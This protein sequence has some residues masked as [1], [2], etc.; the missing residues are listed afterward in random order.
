MVLL[1][2]IWHL[3]QNRPVEHENTAT[4]VEH[5]DDCSRTAIRG[6]L[7]RRVCIGSILMLFS[8]G[9]AATEG[10]LLAK[11]VPPLHDVQYCCHSMLNL[12]A[13]ILIHRLYTL[14]RAPE[15]NPVYDQA[16]RGIGQSRRN[17]ST[18]SMVRHHRSAL[19]RSD[20][21][22]G[23]MEQSISSVSSRK[24]SFAPRSLV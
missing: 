14:D 11:Q 2:V 21:E 8:V 10:S 6:V 9:L 18:D 5:D 17:Q 13:M 19:G 1:F 12:T 4:P 15:K 3:S 7:R 16:Q 20:Y 23:S 22:L 24:A